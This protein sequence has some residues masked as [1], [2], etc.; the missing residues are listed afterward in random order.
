MGDDISVGFGGDRDL[1]FG[2]GC[3]LRIWIAG[4]GPCD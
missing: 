4:C 3:A 1:G 2:I